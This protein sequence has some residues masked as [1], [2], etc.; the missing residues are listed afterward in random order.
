MATLT[1]TIPNCGE[2][3]SMSKLQ[4]LS[5][6]GSLVLGAYVIYYNTV[7]KPITPEFQNTPRMISN[8]NVFT[9]T[10][11]KTVKNTNQ[12]RCRISRTYKYLFSSLSIC[13]GSSSTFLWKRSYTKCWINDPNS[14]IISQILLVSLTKYTNYKESFLKHLFWTLNCLNLGAITSIHLYPN[15]PLN[16]T[17]MDHKITLEKSCS[18]INILSILST[19]AIFGV[20]IQN[21]YMLRINSI[22]FLNVAVGFLNGLS[23][24]QCIYPNKQIYSK[25]IVTPT[26]LFGALFTHYISKKV[27]D[28]ASNCNSVFFMNKHNHNLY[29]PINKTMLMMMHCVLCHCF[30]SFII[31]IMSI[32][33]FATY[34]LVIQ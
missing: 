16:P 11:N 19:F 32:E 28:D 15:D 1:R 29:D 20:S 24:S 23:I 25:L 27:F 5:V 14:F 21:K 12:T 34:T 13:V 6:L 4:K 7:A 9:I 10:T 26:I 31:N 8:R 3:F 33:V 30:G 18:M 2:N 22:S 17:I